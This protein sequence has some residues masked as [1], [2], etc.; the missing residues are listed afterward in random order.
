MSPKAQARLPRRPI[1]R[2]RLAVVFERFFMAWLLYDF[3]AEGQT[4]TFSASEDVS[5]SA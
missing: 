5:V 1:K 4:G 3:L 2:I